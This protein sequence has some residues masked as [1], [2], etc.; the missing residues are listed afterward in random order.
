M[1]IRHILARHE[2]I[3]SRVQRF[4]I[5]QDCYIGNLK[6]HLTIFQAIVNVCQVEIDNMHKLPNVQGLDELFKLGYM[7]FELLLLLI[8]LNNL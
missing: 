3:N 6:F 5:L 8:L 1:W 7:L 4:K 2:N